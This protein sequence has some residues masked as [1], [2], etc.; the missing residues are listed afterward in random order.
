MTPEP[1]PTVTPP[2]GVA[3]WVTF[4]SSPS[5]MPSAP[6]A[7]SRTIMRNWLAGCVAPLVR[8]GRGKRLM[9]SALSSE[10]DV[11]VA[12]GQAQAGG[13]GG[14]EGG[15]AHLRG[16]GGQGEQVDAGGRGQV[17]GGVAAVVPGDRPVAGAG[18]DLHPAARGRGEGG[19]GQG[20]AGPDGGDGGVWGRPG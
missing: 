5:V 9:V 12:P 20:M 4:R 18:V 10:G 6:R 19:E 13:V 7:R 14:V 17:G 16:A 2:P 11:G 3:R 1:S 15:P 8:R